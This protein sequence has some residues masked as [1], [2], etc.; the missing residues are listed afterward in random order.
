[1]GLGDNMEVPKPSQTFFARRKN[2]LQETVFYT[3]WVPTHNFVATQVPL[4]K[5][6][7]HAAPV[8]PFKKI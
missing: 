2:S 3:F 4:G 5:S 7:T 6:L 1:M 8:Y